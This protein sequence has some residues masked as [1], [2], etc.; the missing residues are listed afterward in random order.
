MSELIRIKPHHFIDM[1]ATLG[2]GKRYFVPH[3]HGHAQ[4]VV[5]A[6]IMEKPDIVLEIELAADDICG[7]C[8]HNLEGICD[9]VIDISYRPEAPP[10]KL[11]WNLLIDRRWCTV[12]G[13]VQGDR[14]SARD[15]CRC[16]KDLDDLVFPEVYREIPEHLA[17]KKA[18]RMKAGVDLL[19]AVA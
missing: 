14:L 12:L 17:Q 18:E 5:A 10:M 2:E 4:H 6:K 13:L 8:C 16:L 15:F 9:D 7:P 19:L 11:E 1:V 3:P